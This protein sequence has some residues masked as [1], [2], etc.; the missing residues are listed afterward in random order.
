MKLFI[1]MLRY[2]LVD[3]VRYLRYGRLPPAY[4][5]HLVETKLVTPNFHQYESHYRSIANYLYEISSK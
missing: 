1:N 5:K 2:F 4:L 3:G